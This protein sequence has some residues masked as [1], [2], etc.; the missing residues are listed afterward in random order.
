[1]VAKHWRPKLACVAVLAHSAGT[2]NRSERDR[3]S[4]DYLSSD[5]ESRTLPCY[6]SSDHEPLY[7]FH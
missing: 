7:V 3:G 2:T 6:L 4:R 1:M 5:R